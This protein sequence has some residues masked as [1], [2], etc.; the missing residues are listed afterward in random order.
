MSRVTKT[1]RPL[2]WAE[3]FELVFGPGVLAGI[4]LGDWLA[5]LC[6]NGFR[7]SPRYLPRAAAITS[8]SLTNSM[9][10]WLENRRHGPAIDAAGVSAPLFVLGHW[11]SGTT[12]LHDLLALDERFACPTL[13]EVIYPHTFLLTEGTGS[14]LLRLFSPKQRP[15]DNMRLDPSAAWE[16]EFAMCVWEFTTPY[17]TWAFPSRAAHYDRFLTFADAPEDEVER[18]Q[19]TLTR[20]LK[21]LSLKYPGRRLVLK[22]PTHTARVRF[23]LEMFPD[24]RFVHIHRNPY[25]VYQSCLHL[26]EAALPMIRLQRTER[27]DWEAR[28]R[29]QYRE[30]HDAFFAHRDLIPSGRYHEVRFDD[31]TRDPVGQVKT[32]YEA[33]GLPKFAAAEPRLREYVQSIASYQRNTYH[34]LD[35]ETRQRV[36]REWGRCFEAWGYPV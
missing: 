3:R 7:I 8:S 26:Y 35:A 6:D 18:W 15:Q 12:L 28:V 4:S 22:S 20:Y 30:M 33:L 9:V 36:A 11:R 19:R 27:I 34:E 14:A 25:E 24:A 13:Y 1:Q 17:L 21:K 5:L 32:L 2:T 31:L 29:R 10:R 23:L 16:D